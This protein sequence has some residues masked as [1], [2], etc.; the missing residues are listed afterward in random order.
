MSGELIARLE[1]ELATPAPPEVTALAAALADPARDAA[2]L[3]Y[4][5]T[6]RTGDLSGVLDFYR[7]TWRPHRR[8]LQG[9]VERLLWPEISY[10]EVQA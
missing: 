3:Y 8:G 5:S 9:L 7:L 6:L 1:A 2:I 10:H 4:G